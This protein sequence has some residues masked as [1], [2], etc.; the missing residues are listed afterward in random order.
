MLHMFQN[1]M[2]EEPNYSEEEKTV[3]SILGARWYY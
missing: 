2:N 3:G 1:K